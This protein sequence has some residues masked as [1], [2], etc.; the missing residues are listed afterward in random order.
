MLKSFPV[1]NYMASKQS[2]A[3]TVQQSTQRSSKTIGIP[4]THIIS[5]VFHD[6]V[7]GDVDTDKQYNRCGFIKSDGNIVVS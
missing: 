2:V 6:F 5:L 3:L 7:I 1:K 4:C